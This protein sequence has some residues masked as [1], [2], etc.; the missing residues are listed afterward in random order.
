MA[1][2]T[3]SLSLAVLGLG[4]MG[5]S[6]AMAARTRGITRS[7]IGWDPCAKACA[8]ALAKG[9]VDRIEINALDAAC[10]SDLVVL[11][12]P[13]PVVAELAKEIGP[14][15]GPETVVTDIGSTKASI[16]KHLGSILPGGASFVGSHPI[17]GSEKSGCSHS[18]AQLFEGKL[19]VVCPG[20]APDSAVAKVERFWHEL[21]CRTVQMDPESHD[22][23]LASTSHLPHLVA[24]LLAGLPRDSDKPFVGG[25]FRDTTRIAG[26]D[27]LLWAGI[28]HDNRKALVPLINVMISD[29]TKAR[30]ALQTETA[31]AAQILQEML[32]KGHD[33]RVQLDRT[34]EKN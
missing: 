25:G 29:I 15:C 28:L 1:G 8:K 23:A 19:T 24:F 6:V 17:A 5:G 33:F 27:P 21:G 9:I 4:M 22:Q 10:G 34:P 20:K 7:I 12:C 3:M 18:D 32:K 2:E 30:D 13:V 16:F 11:A 31:E 26:S 14:A